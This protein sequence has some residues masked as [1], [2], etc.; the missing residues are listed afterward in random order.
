[1]LPLQQPSLSH[2]TP[3]SFRQL[4]MSSFNISF[5]FWSL[6]NYFSQETKPSKQEP[7]KGKRKERNKDG[8]LGSAGK[9]RGA[10][11]VQA[12]S[13]GTISS[14]SN[15]SLA[16]CARDGRARIFK[17]QIFRDC[18]RNMGPEAPVVRAQLC[19]SR[20]CSP[21]SSG[22]ACVRLQGQVVASVTQ[23]GK[24]YSTPLSR[25]ALPP[26]RCDSRPGNTNALRFQADMQGVQLSFPLARM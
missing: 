14:R 9:T 10:L 21:G 18:C 17:S 3:S 15:D 13:Q 8:K 7:S 4:G 24:S 1:M 11:P 20:W 19:G 22:T 23:E 2:V 25:V 6:L 5:H 16:F 26:A 12:P